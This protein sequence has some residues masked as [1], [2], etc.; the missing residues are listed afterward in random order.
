SSNNVRISMINN[1]S[2]DPNSQNT[3]VAK[4]IWAALQTQTSNNAK[5]FITKMAKEEIAKALEAGAD[6]LEFA[7]GGMDINIFKEAFES[8]KVDFILSHAIYCRDVLKLKKGQRAVISN[9]R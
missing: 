5:N 8:S 7:V 6:I 2:K 4:A 1:P 3:L 9:G